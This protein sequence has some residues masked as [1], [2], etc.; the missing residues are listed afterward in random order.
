MNRSLAK[1]L[2]GGFFALAALVVLSVRPAAAQPWTTEFTGGEIVVESLKRTSD[3][4]VLLKG[5]LK[6]TSSQEIHAFTSHLTDSSYYFIAKLQDLKT[7][8]QY[9]QVTVNQKRVGALVEG[10]HAGG[11]VKVW[12]RITAPPKDVTQVS[13]QFGEGAIPI[14]QAT[15][16][17]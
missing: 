6:N 5:T 12:A 2:A 14:D 16:S 11:A 7:K 3:D 8:K 10:I 17:E 1:F 4:T 15:I 13:V 9:E